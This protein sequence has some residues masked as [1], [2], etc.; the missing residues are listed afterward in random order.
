MTTSGEVSPATAAV[1][2]AAREALA[3][4]DIDDFEAVRRGFVAPLPNGGVILNADGGTVW[5]LPSFAYIGPDTPSPPT[6]HPSL[7]RQSQL[8]SQAG[9]FEV[10]E[11]IYQ[12]RNHDLANVTIIEGD[13]A[14]IVMDPGTVAECTRVAMDLYFEHRPR[15]AVAAVIYTH[16][17]I[18]HFGGVLGAVSPD[19]VAEGRTAVIAPGDDFN[20]HAYGENII[21]GNAMGRRAGHA[22]GA[23]LPACAT[24]IVSDGIALAQ[25]KAGH[26]GYLPP[27]D[28]IRHTGETRRIAGLTFVFQM[29]PDTEAPEEFHF[30]IPELRA[31]TCAENANHTMHNI[32]TLRGAR[33]R[34]AANFARY[35]DEAI[36]LFGTDVDVHYGPHTWPVWGHDRVVEFLSSQRDAYKYLHDQTLRLANHGLHPVEISEALELPAAIGRR[37]WNRGYHGTP[38]HNVRAVYHKELGW[39]DGNPAS[40]DPLPP[41]E[42]ARRW[43]A[44]AGGAD[45]VVAAARDALAADDHRW[46]VELAGKAVF[47]DPS[48][49]AAREVQADA[50]EQLGFQ[51]EGPQWRNIYL[52]AAQ[53]LRQGVHPGER[54]NTR[55]LVASM[56]PDIFLDLVAVRLNG[57]RAEHD[58]FTIDVTVTDI[59]QRHSIHVRHGVLHHRA[60]PAPDADVSAH[61]DPL[62]ADR[63]PVR[64]RGPR[65]Q[66]RSRH[67]RDRRRRRG[68]P[69]PRRPARPLRRQLRARRTEPPGR[70][71]GQIALVTSEP[72]PTVLD[73]DMGT[74]VDDALALISVLGSETLRLVGITTV[75][76]DAPLRAAIT[77]R[78]LDLASIDL[79]VW[80]GAS[81]PLRPI[82]SRES[83]GPWE[84][85]EGRGIL[86]DEVTPEEREHLD[87][88][89]AAL[90][91]YEPDPPGGSSGVDELVRLAREHPGL[92]VICI[93]PLTNIAW[94]M[95]RDPDFA[96]HVGRLVVLGGFVA[97]PGQEPRIEHNFCSDVGAV[98]VV[99]RSTTPVTLMTA[100]V[101]Q[102][103]FVDHERLAGL[104]AAADPARAHDARVDLDLLRA[105]GPDAHVHARPAD[106]RRRRRPGAGV[107]RQDAHPPRSRRREDPARSAVRTRSPRRCCSSRTCGSSAANRCSTSGCRPSAAGDPVDVPVWELSISH[108]ADK[109][110]FTLNNPSAGGLSFR[111]TMHVPAAVRDDIVARTS[112]GRPPADDPAFDERLA[113]AGKDVF[114]LLL[115]RSIQDVLGKLE[116]GHLAI[117]TDD[118]AILWESAFLNDAFLGLRFAI[119]RRMI[120]KKVPDQKA[121][122][123]RP[124]LDMLVIAD[125][126]GDL[127]QAGG[128]AEA[129][130]EMFAEEP[131]VQVR[132]LAGNDASTRNVLDQLS[133]NAYDI[134]HYA[135]HVDAN[136]P[137]EATLKLADDDTPASYLAQR[138]AADK[139]QIVFVNGCS[140]GR[141]AEQVQDNP[142]AGGEW[143]ASMAETFLTE[144]VGSY[145]GTLW[146]VAD[147]AASRIASRFYAALLEGAAVGDA[148][149]SARQSAADLGAAGW[150]AYL[151]YGR[152]NEMISRDPARHRAAPQPGRAA[153]AHRQRQRGRAPPGG[154][155]TGQARPQRGDQGV[156]R[157]VP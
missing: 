81:Q 150:G 3:F 74:D 122:S 63:D 84:W 71:P 47:A 27:T 39:Y 137:G 157:G 142:H 25:V 40:L 82:P 60:R 95:Q 93:G 85:H 94:A 114:H 30:Y 9:L 77:A 1:H 136:E 50:L 45:E 23:L 109:Y 17:H 110:S 91:A 98:E 121:R 4:D 104:R 29:A 53:E 148:L 8:I 73:T 116:G 54:M 38:K 55:G 18:D 49:T 134:V 86:Y 129:I 131:L 112:G 117:S 5:D 26:A 128:E 120:A 152:P 46:V 59:A 56:P 133:K 147:D 41:A 126:R 21:A 105:Q 99:F 125:P 151:L 149:T 66:P 34:D 75:Y 118:P 83:A 57:P 7:W 16:T 156:G 76:V 90:R 115:P 35:L 51:A 6:V 103:S 139:P 138:L 28:T 72:I 15:Q 127:R 97:P 155:P 88:G 61:A 132:V 124:S 14:L 32:Q 42:S 68:G 13:D 100:D 96:G 108:V 48:N 24:G 37:W 2:A 78:L 153:Q 113:E 107:V 67:R 80:A 106:R 135:G 69:P 89:R 119:A 44:L 36:D 154:D 11:R 130:A 141:L 64:T 140:S 143:V 31:L 43:V 79:P 65:R 102:F 146:D 145:V 87:G 58:D 20:R 123:E 144:G 70:S 19:D 62:E 12:V 52:S 101:T 92:L 33:T 10:S 22:F 111:E